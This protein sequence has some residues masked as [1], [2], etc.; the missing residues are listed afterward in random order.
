MV[1]LSV[2]IGASADRSHTGTLRRIRNYGL[3]VDFAW[4]ALPAASL[5]VRVCSARASEGH[6]NECASDHA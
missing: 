4:T 6:A 1:R 5:A 3:S 2:A